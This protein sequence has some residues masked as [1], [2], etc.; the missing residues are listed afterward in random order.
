MN[1]AIIRYIMCWVLQA[2]GIFMLLPCVVAVVYGES[3]GWAFFAV[4]LLCMLIGSIGRHFKPSSY[5]F[6]TKES[7]VIVALCW[8]VMSLAGALPFVLCGEIPSYIDALFETVSG[9]T[10]TGASILNDVEALSHCCLFWRSF[11]HWLGG[12]GVLVL[13][14]TVMPAVGGYNMYLM[15][16]ESPG[17]SVG[18][19]VP[20]VRRTAQILYGIYMAITVVEVLCLLISGLP[21]F[22]SLT[23]A[24]G[25][26][27][28]GGFGILNDSV[29]SYTA[30]QQW[31][32]TIFMILFGINFNFYYLI[33][34]RKAGQAFHSE[35]V[36]TYLAIIAVAILMILLN[37]R[38][39]FDTFGEA[40]RNTSF[41]VASIITTTG[42]ATA[43]FNLW[44]Q[45]SKTIL[46]LLMFV[47]ACAGSTGGGMKVSRWMILV[48]SARN[49]LDRTIHPHTV[50]RV[51]FDGRPMEK[52]SQH[53]VERFFAI[54]M[55]IFAGSFLIVSLNNLDFTSTFTAIAATINN[56]GPGL[57]L[58]GPTANYS[59]MSALSKIVLMFDMLIGR[60]EIMPMM[61]LIMPA[62]WKK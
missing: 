11:T 46:V 12:M 7:M 59:C 36:R 23:M 10:T 4:M 3:S 29:A 2:E 15:Q 32:F 52:T 33:L 17:P 48:K 8:I 37:V 18:K 53:S 57:E 56:I 35:E 39:C 14:L 51:Y 38:S 16:A 34:I 22:D 54:Y 24:F 28:T 21:L 26:A 61:M 20:Q 47:G 9:F 49:E 60:L 25:T 42:F 6:Y 19:L 50:K 1:Y 44:P 41:T 58:V 45:F 5:V 43:D 31:I 30:V 27:G 13:I 40:L 62:T 55:M